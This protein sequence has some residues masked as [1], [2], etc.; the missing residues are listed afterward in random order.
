MVIH[1]V[2]ENEKIYSKVFIIDS[3]KEKNLHESDKDKIY[4]FLKYVLNVDKIVFVYLNSPIQKDAVS[5]GFRMI[6]N[7]F[8]II[9]FANNEK[10][11]SLNLSTSYSDDFIS[12]F[13]KFISITL[14]KQS[15]NKNNDLREEIKNFIDNKIKETN[16]NEYI[17]AEKIFKAITFQPNPKHILKNIV[18]EE[19]SYFIYLIPK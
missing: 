4:L 16:K 17:L 19:L 7:I 3:L 1:F 6:A 14:C 12:H 13:K 15:I 5:C 2:K 10:D 11:F 18:Q 8:V 9:D